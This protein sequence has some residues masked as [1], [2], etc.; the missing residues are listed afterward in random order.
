M[1]EKALTRARRHAHDPRH[2]RLDGATGYGNA[3]AEDD[4][5]RAGGRAWRSLT[6]AP[7]AAHANTTKCSNPLNG[8][9]SSAAR[10][11]APRR[12]NYSHTVP[13]PTL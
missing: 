4:R 7:S 2:T 5:T 13:Q 3:T 11:A 1:H 10:S 6:R 9:H 12:Y 8:P